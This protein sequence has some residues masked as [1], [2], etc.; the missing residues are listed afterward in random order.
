M[1]S[2]KEIK[3]KLN[4]YECFEEYQKG[5]TLTGQNKIYCNNCNK[6]CEATTLD[7][8][9]KA[10]NILI[11]IINRGK[12]NVFKCDID[13]PMELNIGKYVKNDNSPKDY[14][15]IGVISHLG[16][17]SQDGHFI[18]MCKHFDGCWYL[19]NDAIVS[20]KSEKDIYMG[21]P[22]ILFYQNKDLN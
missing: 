2:N 19:F 20:Q 15:L 18:A 5:E 9:Y 3:R 12:G 10:P 22:Y 1:D 7:E 21:V 6:Q 4:L 17:S 8:I 13:F 16:E 11:I 14:N